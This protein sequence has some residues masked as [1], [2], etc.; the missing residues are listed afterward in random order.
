MMFA[1]DGQSKPT[2]KCSI[3]GRAH[4][5]GPVELALIGLWA[6]AQG[7]RSSAGA[8]SDEHSQTR[9]FFEESDEDSFAA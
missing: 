8:E 9:Q 3:L 4:A 7:W 1:T 6:S 5:R 2:V